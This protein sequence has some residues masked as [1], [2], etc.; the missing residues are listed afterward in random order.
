MSYK[1]VKYFQDL[2]DYPAAYK[3]ARADWEANPSLKWPKNTISWLLIHMMKI[4]ARAYAK[5]K[6]LL[7]LEEFKTL[8]IPTDDR[9]LWGAVAWPI[10]DIV[11][12]SYR[13]QWFTPDFGNELFTT[14]KDMPFDKPSE[15]Y[16][17]M[18]KAF[19][20]L[21]GLWPRLAE[22]IEWWGFDNFTDFD[23]RRYPEKGVL[24]SLA[25]K[26]FTAYLVALHRENV[27]REP[28]QAF[29]NGLDNLAFRS[30]EQANTIYKI[31]NHEV[32]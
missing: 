28:P 27:Y 1:Q 9:K 32:Y 18:G 17:A 31:M 10:R 16:S 5:N 26:I 24:V 13:M 20:Q 22:F 3:I 25:E 21:G 8:G 11:Q 29:F 23:Y 15:A 30:K 19:I 7:Q 6:F 12:D 4:N 14:I 2:E